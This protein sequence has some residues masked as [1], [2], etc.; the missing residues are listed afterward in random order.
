MPMQYQNAANM[1]SIIMIQCFS[2]CI[3]I[4]SFWFKNAKVLPRLLGCSFIS[5]FS[6]NFAALLVNNHDLSAVFLQTSEPLLLLLVMLLL[7]AKPKKKNYMLFSFVMIF[8]PATLLLALIF[9][10][11]ARSFL[12]QQLI[13]LFAS[14]VM[15][16]AILYLLKREKGAMN[17]LFWSF[18]P[19]LLSSFA[20]YYLSFG[21]TVFAAPFLRLGAYTTLLVF[22]YRVFLKSLLVKAEENEKK[23][24]VINRV[25]EYEVKKRMLEIEKVNQNLLNISKTDSLSKVLNKAALQDSI[26]NLINGK[27][28]LAF[29]ILLFDI[30]NFKTINDTLGHVVGDKCIKM[31]CAT[32]KKNIRDFDLVGRYGGDEFVIVLPGTS[33]NEAIMIAE[34][35][36]Q[37]VETSDSPHY[38]ISIGVASYPADG[39]SFKALIAAA[40]EGL[41]HSKR[42]EKNAVSHRGE[43]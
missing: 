37:R 32:A 17:L 24:S 27:A 19:L 30:D 2:F 22:F 1:L 21:I 8:A 16:A 5:T 29:S 23:L 28:G 34:R 7:A 4:T 3:I 40:D 14:L 43:Y 13:C 35:F 9:S 33:T 18:L 6:L 26:E 20:Q 11:P 31:L 15:S 25:I 10:S 36:R 38:T 41:Y 12:S 39:D 42:N